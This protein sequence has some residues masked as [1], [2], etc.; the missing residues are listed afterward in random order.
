MGVVFGRKLGKRDGRRRER[1]AGTETPLKN[2]LIYATLKRPVTWIGTEGLAGWPLLR[3]TM[4][5]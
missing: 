2:D 3:E 5:Q 1:S 4:L